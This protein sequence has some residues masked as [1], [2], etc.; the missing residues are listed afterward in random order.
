MA[1]ATEADGGRG[2]QAAASHAALEGRQRQGRHRL[3]EEGATG[4]TQELLAQ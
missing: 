1:V 3:A 4:G 2:S